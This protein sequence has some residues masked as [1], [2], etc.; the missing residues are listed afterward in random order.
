MAARSGRKAG[1]T[2][3][4]H[5]QLV[6]ELVALAI[7]GGAHKVVLS[8]D[9]ECWELPVVD[10]KVGPLLGAASEGVLNHDLAQELAMLCSLD[11][12]SIRRERFAN[13]KSQM[14]WVSAAG[15]AKMLDQK[16]E[17]SFG[18]IPEMIG[19][20]P[21]MIRAMDVLDELSS[22]LVKVSSSSE[23]IDACVLACSDLFSSTVMLYFD[24][25]SGWIGP[26]GLLLGPT[27]RLTAAAQRGVLDVFAP[28]GEAYEELL[29]RP[30][31]VVLVPLRST[32]VLALA[33]ADDGVQARPLAALLVQRFCRI[34]L[35]QYAGSAEDAS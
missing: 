26:R 29:G 27:T 15:L 23:V 22:T 12:L 28:C 4:V 7:C 20:S 32:V 3:S 21:D 33:W 18:E 6:Q 24:G 34:A 10:G 5:K 9:K 31:L 13:G 30:P 8:V 16:S 1:W 19:S 17:G 2:L 25:D 14:R 35:R 11:G